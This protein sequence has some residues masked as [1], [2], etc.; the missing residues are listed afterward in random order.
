MKK[1]ALPLMIIAFVLLACSITPAPTTKPPVTEPPVTEPPVTE[2]PVTEP[3]VVTNVACNELSLYL[4]PALAASF[5]CQVVPESPSE[6]EIYP[7]HTELTFHGYLLADKFPHISV[8][9]IGDYAALLPDVIPGRVAEL[10]SIIASGSIPP[11][12][13]SFS[14]TLPFLPTFNAAQVFYAQEQNLAFVNGSGIR[15]I[16]EYAQ[17]YAPANNHDLF[18]TYQGITSDGLYWI[19]VILPINH[20]MLP[21]NAD[22]PPGGMT[23]EEFSNNYDPYITDMVFQLNT[24]PPDSYI[25]TLFALDALVSSIIVQP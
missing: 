9:P 18:Y 6:M 4:D 3:P 11:F 10:Q 1:L 17:Y 22:N 15:F 23:W 20:P 14:S 5:D 12:A 7:A 24:Q 25:P 13:V 19:S 16:T 8:Y 2:P 21:A